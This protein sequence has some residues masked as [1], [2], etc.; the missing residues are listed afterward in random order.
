MAPSTHTTL[1]RMDGRRLICMTRPAILYK[2]RA[3]SPDSAFRNT[4]QILSRSE[5]YCSSPDEFNDPFECQVQVLVG[6]DMAPLEQQND[7]ELLQRIRND[8]RAK[9]R[10]FSM[11]AINNNSLMWSHYADSHRGICLGFSI[12][13]DDEWFGLA[14]PVRYT[15]ELPVVDLTSQG[16]SAKNFESIALCKDTRWSYEQEW[17]IAS[18]EP[19]KVR[20]FPSHLLVE[21]I[22]GCEIS[23]RHRLAIT[24]RVLT[25]PTPARLYQAH[26]HPMKYSVDFESRGVLD[27]TS[28]YSPGRNG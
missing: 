20:E 22:L 9:L 21:V 17:R 26:R 23:N 11:S 19:T 13:T 6:E 7:A 5:I 2:Y 25:R 24:A 3:L 14:A 18:L 28:I 27:I 4:M 10:I 16:S 8:M 1:G 12:E 15:D